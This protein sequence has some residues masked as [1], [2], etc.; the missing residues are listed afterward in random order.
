VR[1]LTL[2]LAIAVLALV[3]VPVSGAVSTG[4]LSLQTTGMGSGGGP[5]DANG[6]GILDAGDYFDLNETLIVTGSS[7]AST[8]VGTFATLSGRVSLRTSQTAIAEVVFSLPAGTFV[9]SGG[10]STSVFQGATTILNLHANGA[11]GVFSR[12]FGPVRVFTGNTTTYS[13]FFN[14][15]GVLH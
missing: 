14:S 3:A 13:V 4:G 10:F 7:L 11:R 9:V 1:K 2:V 15:Y 8:P 5:T 6:N 12:A